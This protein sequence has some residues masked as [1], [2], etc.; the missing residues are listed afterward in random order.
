M[1][2]AQSSMLVP[3]ATVL[4]SKCAG[5]TSVFTNKGADG[6]KDQPKWFRYTLAHDT[7]HIVLSFTQNKAYS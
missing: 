3:H 7:A 2:K 6:S 1:L 4:G 5:P